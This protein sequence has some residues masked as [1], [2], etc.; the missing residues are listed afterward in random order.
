LSFKR[1]LEDRSPKERRKFRKNQTPEAVNLGWE[2]R[3]MGR[4]A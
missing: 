4:E 2:R 3:G 1:K